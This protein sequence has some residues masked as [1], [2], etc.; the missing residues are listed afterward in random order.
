MPDGLEARLRWLFGGVAVVL[1]ATGAFALLVTSTSEPAQTAQAFS[2][3]QL[4][5]LVAATLAA[6]TVAF[7]VLGARI[8]WAPRRNTHL[9]P[10]F[11]LA[12]LAAF[13]CEALAALHAWR[14]G[15]SWIEPAYIAGASFALAV[16][17]ALGW[18]V[19]W[20]A[21]RPGAA[22]ARRDEALFGALL[23]TL[24]PAGEGLELD[25][26]DP[27]VRARIVASFAARSTKRRPA[28]RLALRTLD[29]LAVVKYRARFATADQALRER[30]VGGL[31]TSRHARLRTLGATLNETVVGAFWN[32]DR[33]RVAVGDDVLRVQALIENGP[34]ADAH[35]AR[36]EAAERAAAEALLVAEAAASGAE[37]PNESDDPAADASSED[38]PVTAAMDHVVATADPGITAVASDEQAPTVAA[39]APA[40]APPEPAVAKPASDGPREVAPHGEELPFDRPWTLGVPAQEAAPRPA[41]G[42]VLSVARAAG[43]TRR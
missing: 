23:A 42:P 21:D 4:R 24:V 31:A 3:A 15:G 22:T 39:P 14:E 37:T 2:D 9:M 26:S 43:P 40:Q 13:S 1:V 8:V 17:S 41:M 35:R 33:V 5:A 27:D 11:A 18:I 7:A 32:D 16:A 34:N 38:E 12:S 30:I 10:V 25:A 28:L 36:R 19:L 20:L 6:A 29:A